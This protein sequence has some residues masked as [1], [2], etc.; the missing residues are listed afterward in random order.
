MKLMTRISS[1]A[2]ALFVVMAAKATPVF[3]A[4]QNAKIEV[5]T[6][7]GSH[8]AWYTQPVWIAIGVIAL[9]L[10]IALIAMAGRRDNTTVVK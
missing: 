5:K 2:T 10:I 1:L 7:D 9:V 3:A 6:S 4:L 8:G